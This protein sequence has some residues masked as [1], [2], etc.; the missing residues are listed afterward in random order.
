MTSAR[1]AVTDLDGTLVFSGSGR[2]GVIVDDYG[3][4]RFGVTTASAR[5]DLSRICLSGALVVVTTRTSNQFRRLSFSHEVPYALTSNGA[6][7]LVHGVES[8]QWLDETR[9]LTG[10]LRPV[11]E[12]HAILRS[13]CDRLGQESPRRADEWLF[14]IVHGTVMAAGSTYAVVRS[15]LRSTGW[16]AHRSGRKIHVVPRTLDKAVAI[17]RFRRTQGVSAW[18]AAGDS[19]ADTSMLAQAERAIVPRGGP[20]ALHLGR[21]PHVEVTAGSGLAASAEVA[22][23]LGAF[24]LGMG[25]AH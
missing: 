21:L 10:R 14:V 23:R 5:A 7:L 24:V 9:S 18:C 2:Q 25:V 1:W 19:A 22:R 11:S 6:R 13:A 12:V 15:A 20:A 8:A 4:E 17:D 16:V 3:G